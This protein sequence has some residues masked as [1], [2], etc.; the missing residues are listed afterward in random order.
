MFNFSLN[1]FKIVLI[2]LK[3]SC[4]QFETG[5]G[6]STRRSVR[7]RKKRYDADFI[8]DSSFDDED[9]I[10][11]VK[12]KKKVESDFDDFDDSSEELEEDVDSED[13]CEDSTDESDRSWGKKK[14]KQANKAVSN[15][16]RKKKPDGERS[17]KGKTAKKKPKA[18][19]DDDDDE[20]DDE[21]ADEVLP[22][23]RRTRGKKLP[24]LLDDDFD[25]SDDG[26]K[27]GVKRPGM[28]ST[29]SLLFGI[30]FDIK[31][32]N[33]FFFVLFSDTPPEE[34]AAFIKKQEE[35]KRMLAE[36][37]N[38]D[39]SLRVPPP[40]KD[41]LST[42]PPQIIQSAKALDVDLKKSAI[43]H[44][45]A[46]DNDSNGFD[47]D[48]PEDFD[49]EDMD[50]DAIAKMMEEEEFAQQQL[51][52]AG[53][54]IRNRKL[55]DALIDPM[56]KDDSPT[57]L[58]IETGSSVIMQSNIPSM[59][60]PLPLSTSQLTIP[61]IPPS[62]YTAQFQGA[63]NKQSTTPKKR[64]R[65]TKDDIS[66]I[67][68]PKEQVHPQ[69]PTIQHT[70]VLP[71][72]KPNTPLNMPSVLQHAPTSQLASQLF[73]SPTIQH[74]S[75]VIAHSSVIQQ[76]QRLPPMPQSIASSILGIAQN[77]EPIIPSTVLDVQNT[78]LLDPSELGKPPDDL[79]DPTAKKRAR[80][81]KK[82]TPTRDS[83]ITSPPNVTVAPGI[84]QPASVTIPN[85]PN[86]TKP[87]SSILSE[88][89]TANPGMQTF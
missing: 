64:G 88:R 7:D 4:F 3:C 85:V 69:M 23:S 31:F 74:T 28:I 13:L 15:K 22:K 26:I 12:K 38:D 48:L 68:A 72:N 63:N 18:S 79:L 21:Y 43:L 87:P 76:Q 30:N 42:I 52:L 17:F 77:R 34:R 35:I 44:R 82:I 37:G 19:D 70:S 32:L 47:D 16:S 84:S 71:P 40:Q 41:S 10:P 50:E 49:P 24:Y 65:K 5:R 58:T 51:K 45:N 60:S 46:S 86:V 53:E 56:K 81:R 67:V 59:V 25:S 57:K 6:I 20:S 36:K 29:L 80:S 11:L 83:L 33:V 27:P 54:T 2:V 39:K 9:N 14:K 78:R 61:D 62:M 1:K 66:P 73:A 8:D 89:L 55:K 75:S